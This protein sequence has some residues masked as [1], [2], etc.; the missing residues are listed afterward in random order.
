[1]A[2]S[3]SASVL[4]RAGL[5]LS[6]VLV[7]ALPAGVV[8]LAQAQ[9][10]PEPAAVEIPSYTVSAD[11]TSWVCAAAPTLPTASAGDDIAYDPELGTGGG[12]LS[13]EVRMMA[14][15]EPAAPELTF[16][17]VGTEGAV[18]GTA[19]GLALAVATDIADP[20][21][22]VVTGSN[23]EVPLAGGLAVARADA[24]DLRGLSVSSCGQPITSAVLVGG[25]TSL[26]S[27]T[28]LV[29]SNPG[30]TVATVTLTGWS[31]TGPLP[32]IAPIVVP[33]GQVQ[34]LLLETISLSERLAIRVDVAGGRVVPT[35]QDSSLDGLIA[36]GTETI[37]PAADPATEVFF[38]AVPLLVADEAAANLRLLNPDEQAA[39]VSVDLLGPDGP[40]ALE[41]AQDTVI[42]PG[43]VLDISLAGVH[44]GQYGIRVSADVP[45]TGAVQLLRT[46]VAGDADP[47]TPPVDVAW[48]PATTAV[49][50]GVL[51]IPA[52]LV[53]TASVAL[54]NAG[55]QTSDVTVVGYDAEGA[56]S[57]EQSVTLSAGSSAPV[58]VP[59]GTVLL[60]LTGQGLLASAVLTSAAADGTLISAVN[61]TGD[62]FSEQQVGVRVGG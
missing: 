5:A 56:V 45:V 53:D 30:Q 6:G 58:T 26:G 48:L 50:R 7:L 28:R 38:S 51:P 16:G 40:E 1:M 62:P 61:I 33:P 3:G 23:G 17:E 11:K 27:S 20:T 25:S 37:G 21:V 34:A 4:K 2:R 31:G 46:G 57:G 60:E 18:A 59:A 9:P 29:L 55:E 19:A 44:E 47:D 43:S 14:L 39:T 22:S 15:G 24:G 13:T 52:A 54:T 32:E 42:E 49:D 10:A 35:L 12:Q 8:W 36:A 41:G